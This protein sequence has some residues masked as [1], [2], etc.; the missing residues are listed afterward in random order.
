[1]GV[2]VVETGQ[3]H[4]DKILMG[5]TERFDYGMRR[6]SCQLYRFSSNTSIYI[7]TRVYDWYT[8]PLSSLHITRR[9]NTNSDELEEIR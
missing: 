2:R 6:S 8:Y 3:D 1:M 4:T 9:V 5:S 7:H